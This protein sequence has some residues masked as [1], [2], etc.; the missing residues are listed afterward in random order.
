MQL[1]F[2]ESVRCG[3][4]A[5]SVKKSIFFLSALSSLAIISTALQTVYARP[6]PVFDPIDIAVS[7]TITDDQGSPL[8]GVSIM[9]RNSTKGTTTDANGNFSIDVPDGSAVLV[10]SFVGFVTQEIPVNQRTTINIRMDPSSFLLDE[11]I[12]VAYGTVDKTTHVGS[13]AQIK[14]SDIALRP[15]SNALNALIGAAPGVQTTMAN[16]A[17]GS[18]PNIRVRGFGSISASNSALYVVDGVP[19]DAGT[20]SINPDDIESISVLKD[21][22][23]TALYGSRGANGVIMIT[24]KKG[25]AKQSNFNVTVSGGVISRGLPEYKTIPLNQYYPAQWEI[26]RNTLVTSGIDVAT[27][28]S[29]ASGLT[30]SH[31]GRTYQG[32]A[33]LLVYNPYNVAK[34]QIVDVNGQLNPNASLRYPEDLNWVDAIQQGG[35][36]RQNYQVSYDGGSDKSTYF[37][38]FGYTEEQGYL[39]K[40][41]YRRF[42]GRINAETQA[43]KWLKTGLN[44]NG[45]YILSNVDGSGDGGTSI[46]N[47]FYVTRYIGPVYPVHEHDPATGA[48][49]LDENGNKVY[50]MGQGR[51][52]TPGRHAIWENLLDE[53]K[54]V[55]GNVGARTFA[56]VEILPGLTATTN[57][58][59]DMQDSHYRRYNNPII[60]DGAPAGRSY[61]EFYRTTSRTWNQLLEYSG[62]AGLHNFSILGGHENYAY[63]YN[64]LYGGRA[65]MIV[66]GVTELPNFANILTLTSY[67]DNAAIESYFARANYDFDKKYILSASIRRDGNSKFHRDARWANFWSVGGAWN[68][69]RE[70]FFNVPWV[71]L[72]KLRAS[73]G[74]VGNDAGLGY[75][76]YQALYDLGRNN[77]AEP[78]F[79]QAS[80]ANEQLT[81]ETAKNFDIGVDF[82]V[83]KGRLAGSLEYFHRTTNGL[84]FPVPLALSNGGTVAGSDAGAFEVNQNIGNLFNKGWELQL[85]GQVVQGPAFN[86]S[87]TLNVTTFKNQITKMPE[88]QKLMQS[89]TKAYSVGHS[90][91]DFYLRE[92]YEVDSQTGAALYRTNAWTTNTRIVN[93]RDTVTTEIAEANYR[94]TGHS[95]IPK[96]YGSMN[97]RLGYKNFELSLVFTYQ[98]GGKVYDSAYGSLMHG[99]NYGT[100]MHVDAL[101]RWQRPGDVTDVP[102]FTNNNIAN[103]AGGSTRYLTNA[104]YFQLNSVI[105]NY[106]LPKD[107]ISRIDCKGV[108]VFVSG[109][110]LALFSARKGMDVS[111]SFNGTVLN[112]YTFNKLLTVGAKFRF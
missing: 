104:S 52:Y 27:A 48:Y 42:T 90:I 62:K 11:A 67:E 106:E 10:I 29:I 73:Y 109:E 112:S 65:G 79:I 97:H 69:E 21:A 91:Y 8:P 98:V 85:T 87:A 68:L 100:A 72:L 49:V 71:E 20:A 15:V 64:Y 16:G 39:V 34:D 81:W 101:N 46:I 23:T 5:R 2:Q 59:F 93:E 7:G 70:I 14:A 3:K 66:D 40:S 105:L 47:P 26:Y 1:P 41:D 86:Y 12:V 77:N 75:Y 22:S 25:K 99:G 76:P 89:G 111:G 80:I 55:R 17:P 50:D 51:P 9:V 61:H 37:A 102:A 28:N 19:Y 84:I 58:S 94:Y 83:F 107:L 30:T 92:F 57:L 56:T 110:N 78:G 18:A 53:R 35:K 95:A 63:K 31:D 38:S 74:S 96:F 54:L 24:T 33:D 108:N 32:I 88:T 44:I 13:A 60:G 43:T 103:Q 4:M 6:V 45:A 82:N 36:S